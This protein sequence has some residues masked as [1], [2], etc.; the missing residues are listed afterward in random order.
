LGVREG[1]HEGDGGEKHQTGREQPPLPWRRRQQGRGTLSDESVRRREGCSGAV[2][3]RRG[4]GLRQ[5]GSGDGTGGEAPIA[6][7][8]CGGL[9][10]LTFHC[11][12]YRPRAG[13]EQRVGGGG[14][15]RQL[16]VQVVTS[17]EVGGLVCE[18]DAPL[19]GRKRLKHPGGDDYPAPDPAER[20]AREVPGQGG[21]CIGVRH[22]VVD[23]DEAVGVGADPADGGVSLNQGVTGAERVT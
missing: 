15:I 12:A 14:Q 21:Q 5:A 7:L 18:H 6:H 19:V 16:N 23:D 1:P 2:S 10:G 22:V 4:P 9:V 13:P 20:V 3:P 17:G 11:Q 8:G